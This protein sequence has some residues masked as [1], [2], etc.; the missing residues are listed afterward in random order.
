MGPSDPD[1]PFDWDSIEQSDTPRRA[2]RTVFISDIHLGSVGCR[3]AAVLEFLHS[4]DCEYLYLVGDIFDGWVG[5]HEGKWSQECTN[6]IRAVLGKAKFGTQVFY[7]PGN[8][9]AG[10]RRL[11]GSELGN[12]IIDH[13]FVHRTADGRRLLVEHGD[14]FD[15]S[16][17]KFRAIAFAGA[18]AYEAALTLN[19]GVNVRRKRSQRQPLDFSASLKHAV[20]RIASRKRGF[21]SSLADHARASGCD[22]VVC[23]HIHRPEI[24][25]SDSGIL[26]V[27]TGDWVEHQ[28]AVVED[29]DGNLQLIEW[30]TKLKDA[31][32]QSESRDD[33]VRP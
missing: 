2:Y 8:H 15:R 7:T 9:D 3:S 31:T 22:G 32:M 10:M 17:T 30:K 20:K 6:V 33:L 18:W 13:S 11:N 5:K 4:V 1:G 25:R 21:K 14:L 12:L 19:R 29:L 24:G 27:N 26:F 28:T 23:G 16:C